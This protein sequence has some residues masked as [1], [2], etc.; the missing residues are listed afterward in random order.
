MFAYSWTYANGIVHGA[1][2]KNTCPYI[3][4]MVVMYNGFW[5]SYLYNVVVLTWCVYGQLPNSRAHTPFASQDASS[6]HTITA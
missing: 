1:G 6:S 3:T 5:K 4:V 2:V